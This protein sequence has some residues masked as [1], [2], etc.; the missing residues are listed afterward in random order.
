MKL[1]GHVVTLWSIK[2]TTTRRCR[3][4]SNAGCC[5]LREENYGNGDVIP[6][7]RR[8]RM[9]FNDVWRHVGVGRAQFLQHSLLMEMPATQTGLWTNSQLWYAVDDARGCVR[10]VCTMMWT[11]MIDSSVE[12]NATE[13][14]PY[15]W[16]NFNGTNSS[17]FSGL[18]GGFRDRFGGLFNWWI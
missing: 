3:L 14:K 13:M 2:A 7:G 6:T 16:Y 18:P 12:R 10:W 1:H 8:R 11:V 15:G 9:V 5:E 4:G 17:G